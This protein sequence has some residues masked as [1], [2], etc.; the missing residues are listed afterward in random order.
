MHKD[1]SMNV[2]GGLRHTDVRIT[3][4]NPINNA[5]YPAVKWADSML[6]IISKGTENL[7]ANIVMV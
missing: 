7:N 1:I 6:G 3:E 2:D 5:V 4:D